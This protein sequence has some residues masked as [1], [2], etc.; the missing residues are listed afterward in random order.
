MFAKKS[1][2][3]HFYGLEEDEGFFSLTG[4]VCP[5]IFKEGSALRDA[6][7]E[8]KSFILNLLLLS[9]PFEAFLHVVLLLGPTKSPTCTLHS[10]ECLT[11]RIIAQIDSPLEKTHHLVFSNYHPPFFSATDQRLSNLAESFS[12]NHRQQS[13]GRRGCSA[14]ENT[15]PP[16]PLS[17]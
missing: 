15:L 5:F 17:Q 16:P 6:F 2:E 12:L 1:S 7:R 14:E 13:T 9:N 8:A 4:R 3:E 11:D 10:L